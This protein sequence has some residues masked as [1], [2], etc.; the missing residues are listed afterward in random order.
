MAFKKEF[1]VTMR[2]AKETKNTVQYKEVD[3]NG[4]P[5]QMFEAKIG[6]LYVKKSDLQTPY[7][8]QL[9]TTLTLSA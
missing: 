1:K 9:Q 5:V 8:V 7:P 6:T 4:N 3:A 2:M